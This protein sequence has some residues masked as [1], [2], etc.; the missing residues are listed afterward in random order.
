MPKH[1][2]WFRDWFDSPYYHL[3]YADRDEQEAAGFINHLVDYLKPAPGAFML[4]VACGRGRH[5]K[6][7]A[8]KGFDVTGIDLAPS[9]IAY[10]LQFEN[11]HLHFYQ[12]DMRML[13]RINYFDYAFNFFTSF[14]YF[15]SERE[16]NNALRAISQSLKRNGIF[17]LDYINST[18]AEAHLISESTKTTGDIVFNIRK[19]CDETHF[20]KNI[21]I[22]DPLRNEPLE[23]TERIRKFSFEDF[24]KMFARQNLALNSTF[25]N[26][27]LAGYDQQKS[28]RMILLAT[29]QQY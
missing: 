2:I 21:I 17:L 12:H 7:L 16:H 19:W 24:I 28:P 10:A 4:D 27:E 23:F 1:G 18:Y 20:Y 15:E 8:E 9:S 5:A 22:Q 26:Y 13:F 29:K 11:E 3:L 25:G 6:I 14:G